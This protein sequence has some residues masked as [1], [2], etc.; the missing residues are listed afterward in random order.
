MAK[1][2]FRLW[3]TKNELHTI[4]YL[5]CITNNML[6]VPYH[7]HKPSSK[8]NT[9]RYIYPTIFLCNLHTFS[10]CPIRFQSLK[11]EKTRGM[12]LVVYPITLSP[13]EYIILSV[14]AFMYDNKSRVYMR[15]VCYSSIAMWLKTH[16]KYE[17]CVI[18]FFRQW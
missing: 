2:V 16:N 3:I 14:H 9:H 5:T 17:K 12:L 8:V 1:N 7:S 13:C 15:Q 11:N 10:L 18:W 4:R 6:Y